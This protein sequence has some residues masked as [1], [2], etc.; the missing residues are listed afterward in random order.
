MATVAGS[1][2]DALL[3]RVKTLSLS[4]ALPVDW[5]GFEAELDAHNRDPFLRVANLPNT[6]EQ[7]SIGDT[8]YNR[9]YGILQISV[10]WPVGSG[11]ADAMEAAGKIAAY[12][13]RGTV[14][15]EN[16][17][18]VRVYRPPTVAP[19]LVDGTML[20]IPVSIPWVCDAQN[21]A[22]LGETI[23]GV[24]AGLLPALV[25]SGEGEATTL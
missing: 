1:I 2:L 10:M 6:A 8:G 3:A 11:I 16:G 7:I 25:G 21:L 24:S 5:P 17:L 18:Y 20:Q 12:F 23:T 19:M 14:V 13:K 4:P 22:G 9:H 15:E